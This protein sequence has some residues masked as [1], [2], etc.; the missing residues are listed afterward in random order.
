L[1]VEDLKKPVL[2]SGVGGQD[3]E[4]KVSESSK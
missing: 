3:G 2:R 4:I 1:H